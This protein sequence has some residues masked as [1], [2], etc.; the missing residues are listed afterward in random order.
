MRRTACADCPAVVQCGSLMPLR[1]RLA[2]CALAAFA[3]PLLPYLAACGGEDR[4]AE[5]ADAVPRAVDAGAA[6]PAQ[7]GAPA[8]VAPADDSSID[9]GGGAGRQAPACVLAADLEGDGV[10]ERIEVYLSPDRASGF[11]HVVR[12]ADDW[13]SPIWPLW[14]AA[15]ARLD[16]DLRT[17]LVLGVRAR[18]RR[19][20]EVEPH[21]TIRVLGAD[22]RG[23][24]ELWRGSA[25]ARPLLDFTIGD[26]D[27]DGLDELISL[28][29][30]GGRCWVTAYRWNG[31]GF[32]GLARAVVECRGLAVC[33]EGL[34]GSVVVEGRRRT[35]VVRN[36][37]LELEEV[38]E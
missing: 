35:P 7:D 34:P 33:A 19:E 36:G 30:L 3:A 1:R 21:R 10:A 18:S 2:R 26:V 15:P 22:G 14:K 5:V 4:T 20:P 38:V 13:T 32:Y 16:G 23:L 9:G 24:R 6:T 17:E 31:F 11:L 12:P 8:S 27:H 37:A 25:L 28:D 29:A